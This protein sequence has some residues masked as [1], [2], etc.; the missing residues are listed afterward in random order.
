MCSVFSETEFRAAA[1]SLEATAANEPRSA[2]DAGRETPA[3][4]ISVA[5][6][7]TPRTLSTLMNRFIVLFSFNRF[8]RVFAFVLHRSSTASPRLLLLL[9]EKQRSYS[10]GLKTNFQ[11]TAGRCRRFRA[12]TQFGL[13]EFAAELAV[14]NVSLEMVETGVGPGIV[15]GAAELSGID[16]VSNSLI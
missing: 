2:A 6:R 7:M 4:L 3:M 15:E 5:V 11:R 14:P 16:L 10:Q 12:S 1:L 8:R 13:A 9:T